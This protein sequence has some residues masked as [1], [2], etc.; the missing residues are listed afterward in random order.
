MRRLP[1]DH[2]RI[3]LMLEGGNEERLVMDVFVRDGRPVE[4][5]DTRRN[6]QP[7][8]DAARAGDDGGPRHYETGVT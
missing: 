8:S 3:Y 7:I 5:A 1:D 6:L 4:P 2:Y